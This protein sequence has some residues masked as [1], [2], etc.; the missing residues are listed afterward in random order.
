MYQADLVSRLGFSLMVKTSSR[1][2]KRDLLVC[3]PN[4][5]IPLSLSWVDTCNVPS[6]DEYPRSLLVANFCPGIC[7]SFHALKFLGVP[8]SVRYLLDIWDALEKPLRFNVSREDAIHVKCGK[9][10]GGDVTCIDCGSL[11]PVDIFTAGPPCPPWSSLGRGKTTEDPRSCVFYA[12]IKCVEHF[13]RMGLKMF[14]LE[15]VVG[16]LK[17]WKGG[18]IFMLEIL[19]RLKENMPWFQF[20]VEVTNSKFHG[21]AQNRPRVFLIGYHRCLVPSVPS[22]D[23][24]L[25]QQM[26][27]ASLW[28]LLAKGCPKIDCLKDLTAKQRKCVLDG[29]LPMLKKEL[30]DPSLRG[31]VAVFDISRDPSK[32]LGAFLRCDDLT[33]TLTCGNSRLVVISLG[34]GLDE[35][36]LERVV[37]SVIGYEKMPDVSAESKPE[38]FRF[39]YTEERLRCHGFPY[40]ADHGL[41]VYQSVKASG[42]AFSVNVVGRLMAPFL[43][44]IVDTDALNEVPLVKAIPLKKNKQNLESWLIQNKRPWK[45]ISAEDFDDPRRF[46]R[47][48]CPEK[49][50]SLQGNEPVEEDSWDVHVE[51]GPESSSESECSQDGH[52]LYK[53]QKCLCN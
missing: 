29:Y 22:L 41:S 36:V 13:G 23:K 15:N 12:V 17:S 10:N 51:D 9:K 49:S 20:R 3:P 14:L 25:F 2:K 40:D 44:A 28:N 26:A 50:D 6:P 48:R 16:V 42:N 1:K 53:A 33:G 8:E 47:F 24:P 34:E 52:R 38:I 35:V 19:E 11:D 18:K 21:L 27:Q 30:S 7:G 43:K 39:L 31:T 4:I 45:L 46:E 32:K 37:A 5:E